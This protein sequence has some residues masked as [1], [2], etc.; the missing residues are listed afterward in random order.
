MRMPPVRLPILDYATPHDGAHRRAKLV[1]FISGAVIG[2]VAGLSM[3]T[4]LRAGGPIF[5]STVLFA[6]IA[7]VWEWTRTE[8]S[9][10]LGLLIGAPLL[11]GVYAILWAL[12]KRRMMLPVAASAHVLCFV[13][14]LWQRDAW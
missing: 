4:I 3:L 12:P 7:V 6:P 9:L 2:A 11:Y 5:P 1:L 14:T 10:I 8:A 13:V